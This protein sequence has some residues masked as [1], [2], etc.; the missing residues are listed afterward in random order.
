MSAA[1]ANTARILSDHASGHGQ[2][3]ITG[4]ASTS[5]AGTNKQSQRMN[6][7]SQADQ[8]RILEKT[9]EDNSSSGQDEDQD[10][11]SSSDMSDRAKAADGP[12]GSDTP[13]VHLTKGAN[14]ES[15]PLGMDMQLESLMDSKISMTS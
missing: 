15:D 1:N 7:D 8:D 10:E 6:L 11:P 3:T 2:H 4:Y 5:A 14:D 12:N 13:Y 9:R